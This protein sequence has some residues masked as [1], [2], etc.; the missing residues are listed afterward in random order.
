MVREWF[1]VPAMPATTFDVWSCTKS[2][3]GIAF[4]LMSQ[5]SRDHKL[6]GDQ[7]IDLES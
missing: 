7:K 3:T 1:G 5:D 4:G 6:P 2:A